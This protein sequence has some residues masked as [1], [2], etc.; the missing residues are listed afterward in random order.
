MSQ[1][2][3]ISFETTQKGIEASLSMQGI[4]DID[5]DIE[6][7]VHQ[8]VDIYKATLSETKEL[9][10]RREK[11]K[12]DRKKVPARLI[13]QIGDAIFRL[14]DDLSC[15]NLQIDNTYSDVVKTL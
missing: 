14:I 6:T 1:L 9:L 10:Q 13:W 15:I 7:V 11:L 5:G 8:A 4:I 3:F 2:T 12:E